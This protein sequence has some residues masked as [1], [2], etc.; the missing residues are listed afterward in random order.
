VFDPQN[1]RARSTRGQKL[2]SLTLRGR[3][4]SGDTT[5]KSGI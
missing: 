1:D 2:G 5:D 4:G 3:G